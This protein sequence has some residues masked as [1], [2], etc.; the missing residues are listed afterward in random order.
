MQGAY[1]GRYES[2]GKQLTGTM[3]DNARD[4]KWTFYK[5]DGSVLRVET[6][7]RGKLVK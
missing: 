3:T 7:V 5:P 6:W 1:E 4:A 2:G